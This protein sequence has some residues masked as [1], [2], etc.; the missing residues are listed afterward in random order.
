MCFKIAA[1]NIK[2]SYKDYTIY[3]LTLI[4]A[5]CIFY[6]FNSVDSQK[7][8]IDIKS[9]N[10]NYI[11]KLTETMS[12][13]SVL[14]SIILGGLILYA[15]NFLIKRRK[16][17]FAIYM[18]LG[19]SRSK[20]SKILVEETLLVGVL[21]LVLGIIFGIAVSQGLSVFMIKSFDV[22]M[23]EY[24][25]TVSIA[26]I[27]KT[28]MYFGI[29]FLL[30]MLFNVFVISRYKII[31]LLTA[32]RKNEKIRIKNPA[33][34]LSVLAISII[35]FVYV[36]RTVL[37]VQFIRNSTIY[38]AAA[39][40]MVSTV[41]FFFGL[42][43]FISYAASRYKKL[44]FKGLNIFVIKQIS[45]R[46][47]TNFLS[48][49]VI[50]IM[51][52][53]TMVVLSTGI[54]AKKNYEAEL[55]N[56]TPFDASIMSYNSG[57]NIE[58]TLKKINFEKSQ[59]EKYAVLNEYE[60]F[61]KLEDVF[62]SND[63]AFKGFNG[64]FIKLSDYNK[65]LKLKGQHEVSLNN[66]EVLIMS[67]YKNMVKP[68][69][70]RLKRS[71][72]VNINGKEYLVKNHEVIEDNLYTYILGDNFCTIVINNKFL[73]NYKIYM[74]VL[75][76]MYLDKNRE[77]SN[78]KYK[79]INHNIDDVY[80][81]LNIR[82]ESYSRDFIYSSHKNSSTTMLFTGLYLGM[83]F[84]ITSMAV[85]A[86][87]Q[88]SEASDSIERY[89]ALKRIG[90]NKKMINKAIFIQTLVYFSLPLVLAF[91]HSLIGIRVVDES[92]NAFGR[93]SMNSSAL[94]TILI[95]IVAYAGYFYTTYTGY[96][97]IVKSNM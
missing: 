62:M 6:G 46:F 91:I 45:S 8:F 36:Y 74:S 17:E 72:K 68:I 43:G 12:T 47:N 92:I 16:K 66:D 10:G 63:K 82:M 20:V 65:M 13:L 50:C 78:I 30:V 67:N 80:N 84:L 93:E 9:S 37:N 26:A 29:I 1:G 3:F 35:L 52:F 2:K 77:E 39:I 32:G 22:D 34:Y 86:L 64:T 89:R 95:F 24:R 81:K 94:M 38:L 59:N 90:A 4:L 41:M 96:K 19:M 60:P 11:S 83:V 79:K 25:F 51:L 71:D 33:V 42:S 87:Q 88:L 53:I 28:I 40:M 69:N 49:S 73:S 7:A 57:R 48:I 27:G 76:V 75:N 85:L 18:T 14:V 21:S 56:I 5:V 70:E 55:E 61:A 15:N 54:S 31:D 44:Y 23:S 58:D 97:S